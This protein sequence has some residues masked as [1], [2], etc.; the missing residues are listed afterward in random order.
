MLSIVQGLA[1]LAVVIAVGFLLARFR[2]L[3][4]NTQEILAR[5]V[6]FVAT[7]ALLMQTLSKAPVGEVFSAALGVTAIA[8]A[9]GGLG[10]FALSRW[11]FRATAGE[12]TIGAVAS[13]YVN[14]G[15]LGIPLTSYLFGTATYVAPVMMY[16]LIVLAP[17]AFVMLDLAETGQS[18]SLKRVLLQPVRNPIVV[19]SL[20]GVGLALSGWQLPEVV[21]QPINLIAGL[22]VPGALIAYGMSLHGAPIPG[23]QVGRAALG[24]IM[25]MK[26]LVLPATAYLVARFIFG[27]HGEPLLAATLCAALPTAQN[28]FVYAVRYRTAVPLA[29]DAVLATT[30]AAVPVLIAIVALVHG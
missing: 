21:A 30:V 26:M 28:V 18:P 12:S 8:T 2:V 3:P 16:Q 17:I 25:V 5:L 27:M 11:W 6:F 4:E 1:V 7:P 20:L 23:K 14:A 10:Y 19:A 22:A 15:N 29:R 9:V 24:A 13:C